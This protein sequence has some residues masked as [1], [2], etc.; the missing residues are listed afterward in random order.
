MLSEPAPPEMESLLSPPSIVSLP[1]PPV[2]V[3]APAPVLTLI[4][5][6]ALVTPDALTESAPDPKTNR[7]IWVKLTVFAPETSVPFSAVAPIVS[8]VA[9]VMVDESNTSPKVSKVSPP[10]MVSTPKPAAK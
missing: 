7:S 4:P 1:A 3:S 10:A 6:A 5:S 8:V 2:M 9:V